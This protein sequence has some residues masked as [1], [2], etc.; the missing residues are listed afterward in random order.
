MQKKIKCDFTNEKNGNSKLSNKQ[1]DALR[2]LAGMRQCTY[3]QLGAMFNCSHTH[4]R[5]VVL[6][7][8]RV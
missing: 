7:K 6:G 4:A 2:F 5:R 3:R 8:A 1:I